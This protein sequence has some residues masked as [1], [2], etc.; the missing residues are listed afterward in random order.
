LC[1]YSL[2]LLA[3]KAPGFLPRSS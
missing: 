1:G 3:K 2:P